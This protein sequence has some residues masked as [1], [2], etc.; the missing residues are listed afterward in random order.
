MNSRKKPEPVA[1]ITRKWGA[2]RGE[3]SAALYSRDGQTGILEASLNGQTTRWDVTSAEAIAEFKARVA[4]EGGDFDGEANFGDWL[5]YN[6]VERSD[7]R[8]R[9]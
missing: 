1:P 4:Q 8:I 3:D 5:L 9:V 6:F 7:V 2:L